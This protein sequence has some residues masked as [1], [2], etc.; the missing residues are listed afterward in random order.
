MFVGCPDACTLLLLLV[1]KP[2]EKF[3]FTSCIWF[4]GVKFVSSTGCLVWF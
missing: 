4:D 1:L 3:N 2:L